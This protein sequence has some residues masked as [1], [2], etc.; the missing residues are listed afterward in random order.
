MP[1]KK[2]SLQKCKEIMEIC[3]SDVTDED[4]ENIR[5]CIYSIANLLLE[6][7]LG[8]CNKNDD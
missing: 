6:N 5:N 8:T 3:P 2:F 1:E 7:Y 4:L